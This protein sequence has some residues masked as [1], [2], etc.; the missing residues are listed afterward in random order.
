MHFVIRGNTLETRIMELHCT[1]RELK[2]ISQLLYTLTWGPFDTEGP[3]LQNLPPQVQKWKIRHQ[4]RYQWERCWRPHWQKRG[5]RT[6]ASW[7]P[8]S[9]G[10]WGWCWSSWRGPLCGSPSPPRGLTGRSVH[11]SRRW[12]PQPW[13][14]LNNQKIHLAPLGQFEECMGSVE[15]AGLQQ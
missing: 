2:S 12:W 10:C 1:L 6:G 15:E 13:E 8:S 4:G 11:A 5:V 14:I 3:V 9:C 7:W